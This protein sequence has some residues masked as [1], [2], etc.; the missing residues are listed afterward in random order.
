MAWI[1]R[2]WDSWLGLVIYGVVVVALLF[3]GAPAAWRAVDQTG[4]LDTTWACADMDTR[5]EAQEYLDD[6]LEH[7]DAASVDNL[8]GDG[9]GK[10]CEGKFGPKTDD[11]ERHNCDPDYP[12]DCLDPDVLDYDCTPGD[13]NGP[14][15]VDGPIKVRGYDQFDLD[16]DGDGWG[17]DT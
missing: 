9:N 8:D 14:R 10:A 1:K 16:R 17:C 3:Y 11:P 2:A 5:A 4:F 7:H 6:E 13:G 12:D 15:F